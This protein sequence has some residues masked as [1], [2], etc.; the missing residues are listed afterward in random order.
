M[1]KFILLLL[2]PL[3]AMAASLPDGFQGIPWGAAAAK[4]AE[5]KKISGSSQY[6]CYRIGDG[7]AVVAEAAVSNLRLCFNQ[8]RFYFAQMEYAGEEMY[9][10][11]LAYGKASWG[12]PKP[13]QR[14][15]EAFVWG[16]PQEGVYVELEFSKIDGRGTL[17]YVYLPIYQETQ[18]VA[19]RERTKPRAG[20]GF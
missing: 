18:E 20:S 4:L 12:E 3:S 10:K 7:K 15:T 9:Q 5:G 8:D 2:L 14:F 19:K 6:D 11:L 1:K 13:G 17:A 16:G